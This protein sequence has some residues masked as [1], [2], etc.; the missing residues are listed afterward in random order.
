M[1]RGYD[2]GARE[3]GGQGRRGR[4]IAV[5][6]VGFVIGLVAA[7]AAPFVILATRQE[8]PVS[9]GIV[10][11]RVSFIGLLIGF[12]LLWAAALSACTGATCNP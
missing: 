6:Y 10:S 5:G 8:G 9:W 4:L 1:Q 11:L 2:P 12:F 3:R 7:I